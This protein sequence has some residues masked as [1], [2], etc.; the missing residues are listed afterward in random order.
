MRTVFAHDKPG[1]AGYFY[2]I[3][4]I[5]IVGLEAKIDEVV[6]LKPG[7]PRQ[8]IPSSYTER[9]LDRDADGKLVNLKKS[10]GA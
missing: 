5:L 6:M 2:T 3:L 9:S 10:D 7:E 4:G 1:A 8:V